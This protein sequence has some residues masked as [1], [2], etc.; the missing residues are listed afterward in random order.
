M[1]YAQGKDIMKLSSISTIR[2]YRLLKQG[3]KEIYNIT[4]L[5]LEMK[6]QR[7]QEVEYIAEKT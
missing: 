1:P 4:I 2:N 7:L 5:I 3:T 6:K